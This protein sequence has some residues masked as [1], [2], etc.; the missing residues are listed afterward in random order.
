MKTNEVIAKLDEEINKIQE[1]INSRGEIISKLIKDGLN[2][3]KVRD[4]LIE[5]RNQINPPK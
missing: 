5:L 1:N 3:A 4:D 2:E